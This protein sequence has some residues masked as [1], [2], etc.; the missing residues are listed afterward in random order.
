MG[1]ISIFL[2]RP[3]NETS[4]S[5]G[6]RKQEM[7]RNQKTRKYELLEPITESLFSA[8]DSR[9]SQKNLFSFVTII[10]Q[11]NVG[12]FRLHRGFFRKIVWDLCLFLSTFFSY[13]IP[14][15][16]TYVL[17]LFSF[18]NRVLSDDVIKMKFLKLWDLSGYSERTMSKRPTCQK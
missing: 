2:Q 1:Y 4:S 18:C 6:F 8:Q 12:M 10:V 17:S 11:F 13:T 16:T 7:R 3:G 14:I 9:R 5:V 15:I